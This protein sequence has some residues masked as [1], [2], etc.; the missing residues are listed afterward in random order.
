[1]EQTERS[2]NPLAGILNFSVCELDGIDDGN[3]STFSFNTCFICRI[4]N[5][6]VA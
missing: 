2:S 5:E 6:R 4:E 1:M 3:T